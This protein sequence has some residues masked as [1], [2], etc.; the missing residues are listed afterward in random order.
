S[1]I[2]MN[3]LAEEI[4]SLMSEQSLLEVVEHTDDE[5]SAAEEAAEEAAQLAAKIVEVTGELVAQVYATKAMLSIDYE[6][7]KGSI[8]QIKSHLNAAMDYNEQIEKRIKEEEQSS[9]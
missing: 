1:L 8:S 6:L 7:L 4:K 2:T 5:K 9:Q 3:D